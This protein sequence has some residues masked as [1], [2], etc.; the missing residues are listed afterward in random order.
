[1]PKLL[2][3]LLL[4]LGSLKLSIL[5]NQAYS[6]QAISSAKYI[7]LI[8][9][10]HTQKSNAKRAIQS[11]YLWTKILARVLF[12]AQQST[13][14]DSKQRQA[15][16]EK[17]RGGL[18]GDPALVSFDGITLPSH[19]LAIA[20][21]QK[22]LNVGS[23][24]HCEHGTLRR[25]AARRY[26]GG[27]LTVEGEMGDEIGLLVYSFDPRSAADESLVCCICYIDAS[28]PNDLWKCACRR[29]FCMNCVA[30]MILARTTF[31]DPSV[32]RE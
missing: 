14:R 10:A 28:C 18:P 31:G 23:H 27:V 19:V 32:R 6:C 12:L 15:I 5:V 9:K 13:A 2:L 29:K 4:N 21:E 30:S 8:Q 1:I 17:L 24:I 7:R 3:K 25:E 20:S 11:G 22:R 26:D 16:I